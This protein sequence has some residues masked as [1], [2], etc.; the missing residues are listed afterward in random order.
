MLARSEGSDVP[1][2][3]KFLENKSAAFTSPFGA[4]QDSPD[5]RKIQSLFIL[6]R[7]EEFRI[8]QLKLSTVLWTF[9]WCLF[10]GITVGS[11][12]IG[13]LFPAANLVAKPFV[14]PGGQMRVVSQDYHPSPVETVT[15][16]T[17][18]CVDNKTGAQTEL[19]L[20]PMS[21][22]AGTIYGLLFFLIVLLGMVL[23]AN[24][25]QAQA[26]ASPG[27]NQA[28]RGSLG[29]DEELEELGRLEQAELDK[30]RQK[31]G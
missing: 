15:T 13:A 1:H 19:G 23:L 2:S 17:W 31:K 4:L 8:M 24:R 6:D 29:R 20:F 10:M 14:C 3:P 11:I 16:L 21:L 25:R 22:Y 7:K 18:Y 9:V 30:K 26:S 27:F 12:G 5:L 28:A